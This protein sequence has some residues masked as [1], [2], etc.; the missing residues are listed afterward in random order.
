MSDNINTPNN[1]CPQEDSSPLKRRDFFRKAIKAGCSAA[2]VAFVG[3]KKASAQQ[4]TTMMVGEEGGY[5]GQRPPY[6]N[7]VPNKGVG[8]GV[9]KTPPIQITTHA[10]GEEGGRPP[11]WCGTGINPTTHRVGEEGQPTPTT[12]AVGEEGTQPITSYAIGEEERPQVTTRALGEEG[13]PP[14]T[15]T[16]RVGEE[17]VRPPKPGPT[18]LMVGEEGSPGRTPGHIGKPNP[19]PSPWKGFQR[20]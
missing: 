9:G 17:S 15:T 14:A 13:V 10:L 3:A 7:G 19:T 16:K 1:D 12:A 4:M 20:W 8:Q 18:T 2:A 5:P 11:Y 6:V